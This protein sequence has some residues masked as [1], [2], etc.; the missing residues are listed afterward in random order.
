MNFTNKYKF[1]AKTHTWGDKEITKDRWLKK[2]FIDY[3]CL[4]CGC[5]A[6]MVENK[7][8]NSID[9]VIRYFDGEEYKDWINTCDEF[10]VSQVIK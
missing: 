5:E 1:I 8:N 7:N 9:Y 4:K 10:I 2:E 3:T 6:I